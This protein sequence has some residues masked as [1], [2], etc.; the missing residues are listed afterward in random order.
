MRSLI[1]SADG[2]PDYVTYDADDLLCTPTPLQDV[3]CGRC[4]RVYLSGGNVPNNAFKAGKAGYNKFMYAI[5]LSRISDQ[6][7]SNTTYSPT[8]CKPIT[9][10]CRDVQYILGYVILD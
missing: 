5:R 7:I 1:K 9:H 3:D 6:S 2:K 8:I 4:T 10:T